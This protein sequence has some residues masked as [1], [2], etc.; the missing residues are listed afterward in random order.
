M[1]LIPMEHDNGTKEL[2]FDAFIDDSHPTIA[3]NSV[4]DITFN[5][6][7]TG[8][9]ARCIGG[10]AVYSG[11]NCAVSQAAMTTNTT[12]TIRVTNPTSSSKTIGNVNIIIIYTKNS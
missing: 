8:Y 7:K 11:S 12:A 9:Q 5:V 6:G 3:A 4:V 2:L 10:F 1:A